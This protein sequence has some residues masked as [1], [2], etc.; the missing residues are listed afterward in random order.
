MKLLTQKNRG[1]TLLEALIVIA[2]FLILFALA[3]I[4]LINLPTSTS[5]SSIINMIISD[6]KSQQIKSMV[7][8]TE[9]RG[10]PDS[11][12]IHFTQNSYVLFHGSVYSDSDTDNYVNEIPLEFDI[13]TTFPLSTIIFASGSGEI[14]NFVA[15]Q[16]TITLKSE[17]T[18][19]Q[20]VI[21]LNK[22]GTVESVN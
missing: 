7:G 19:Q 12:G 22:Y 9:G 20:K 16:N 18:N 21:R 14:K 15:S 4:S 10:A 17:Q 8:D 3:S 5:S 1:F 13:T 6:V 2:I 11:Y